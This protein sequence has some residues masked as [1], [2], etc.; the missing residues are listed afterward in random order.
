M[1]NRYCRLYIRRWIFNIYA[2]S[3][4]LDEFEEMNE[5]WESFACEE[6]EESIGE[7]VMMNFLK[8]L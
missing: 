7:D 6:E 8:N 1:N 2:M 4:F 3:L 5:T